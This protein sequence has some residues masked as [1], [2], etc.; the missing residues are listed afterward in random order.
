[1]ATITECLICANDF[2]ETR[3]PCHGI[4]NHS[5]VCSLCYLRMR[6]LSRDMRCPICKTTLDH[7]ICTDRE[8]ATF[9]DFQIWGDSCGPDFE[10]D[11]KS[12]MFFPR[13]YFQ[14]HVQT[15]WKSECTV[16]K[17][18]KREPFTLKKHVETDHKMQMC[19]LCIENKKS[20]PNEH[21]IYTAFQFEKHMK[22]GD[23]DGS[24]GHPN[25]EFCRRRYYDKNSLFEHIKKDHFSCF[26]CDNEGINYKYFENYNSL[27][28]HFRSQH[29]ICDDKECLAQ[30]FVV[31]SNEV[32]FF[33]HTRQFHPFVNL[34]RSV[35]IHFKSAR[36]SSES[37]LMDFA[38]GTKGEGRDDFDAGVRGRVRAGEW[39]VE[40]GNIA[41]DPRDALR[42]RFTEEMASESL[43]RSFEK[44]TEEDYPSLPTTSSNGALD[45]MVI[46]GKVSADLRK[47]VDGQD[48]AKLEKMTPL[49][50]IK[51]DKRLQGRK[52]KAVPPTSAPVSTMPFFSTLDTSVAARVDRP[53]PV[54]PVT[55][56][57]HV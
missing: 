38:K 5:G 56:V 26:I 34:G 1:M 54:K 49:G 7:I 32:D 55:P 17:V 37:N 35:P 21:K 52:Q 13:T 50:W 47:M 2:D 11:G 57:P 23:G 29:F 43:T 9:Q 10:Y 27:E 22:K 42:Q 20:F 53:A 36:P 3:I 41:A 45:S 19:G 16:C 30:K 46:R 40:L 6:A 44:Q 4:C 51:V 28:K 33:S 14:C 24:E 8:N 12:S 48:N 25:C 15:L 31:F 18:L 39:Q